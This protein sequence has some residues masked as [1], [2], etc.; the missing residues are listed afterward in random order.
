MPDTPLWKKL[1]IKPGYRVLVLNAPADYLHLL[2]DL[3]DG[4][5]LSTEPLGD[6]QFD[7]V[8]GYVS[9]RADLDR[10][11]GPA[12]SN[13]KPGGALWFSYPKKSSKVKTDMDRDNNW[14]PLTGAGLRV[15]TAISIDDTWSGLRFRPLSEVKSSK[16]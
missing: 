6:S 5:E 15:V 14:E 11:A 7:I 1:G 10:L 12:M 13:L 16:G 8:H 9:S 4:V 3:P 2:A